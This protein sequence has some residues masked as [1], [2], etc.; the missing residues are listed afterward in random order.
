MLLNLKSEFEAD[1]EKLKADFKFKLE[2]RVDSI[3]RERKEANDCHKCIGKSGHNGTKGEPGLTG[4][5]GLFG[6]K[7]EAGHHH[8]CNHEHEHGHRDDRDSH[9]DD[10]SH[11]E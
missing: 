9:Q 11:T 6:E 10:T 2:L 1:I 4:P 8:N 3:K 7:G 5:Q